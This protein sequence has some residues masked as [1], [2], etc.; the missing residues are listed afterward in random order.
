MFFCCNILFYA[1][2]KSLWIDKRDDSENLYDQNLID[3]IVLVQEESTEVFNYSI[4]G[5]TRWGMRGEEIRLGC[6]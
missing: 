1:V 4:R 6:R 3:L 5:E 2:V